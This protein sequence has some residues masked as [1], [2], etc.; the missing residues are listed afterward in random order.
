MTLALGFSV[1]TLQHLVFEGGFS[2]V[3][4]CARGQ[5]ILKIKKVSFIRTPILIRGRLIERTET[6]LMRF[7]REVT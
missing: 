5:R 1:V 4:A 2:E 6:N 7:K 3:Y